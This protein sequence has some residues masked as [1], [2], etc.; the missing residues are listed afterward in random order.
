MQDRRAISMQLKGR[1][2]RSL[3]PASGKVNIS[4][5]DSG[6]LV[7]IAGCSVRWNPRTD[8]QRHEQ[9]FGVRLAFI[10]DDADVSA[11]IVAVKPSVEYAKLCM[12]M[13]LGNARYSATC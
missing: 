10:T 5:A 13:R 7:T 11:I 1:Q 4:N 3:L 12:G 9:I 2:L 6:H 8:A